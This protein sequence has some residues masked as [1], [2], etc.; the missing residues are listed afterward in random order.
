MGSAA[1]WRGAY[2]GEYLR[3]GLRLRVR[4]G[5]RHVKYL[6][7]LGQKGATCETT[8]GTEADQKS[9]SCARYSSFYRRLWRRALE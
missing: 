4:G 1:R 2:G 9:L 8:D 7:K 6:V 5:R 3:A